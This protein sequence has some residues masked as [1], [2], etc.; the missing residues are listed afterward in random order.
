MNKTIVTIFIIFYFKISLSQEYKYIP[1][2]DSG[3]IWSEV[4]YFPE[5]RWPDTMRKPPSYERFTVNGE[6]T[7]INDI[8]YKKLFMFYDSV[9]IKN[10]ATFI[11]GI[12]E[13][14]NKRVYFKSD[15]FLH[16]FKPMNWMYDY[17]EIILYDFSLDVGDTIKNINC[18][19]EDD[20]LV[21]SKIDSV[22]ID[23]RYRKMFHFNPMPW[24]K[25]IE[26]IGNL[27]GLLFTSGDIPTNGTYGSLIC[28]K[29]NKK[30]LYF[31]NDYSECFPVLTG[32]ETNKEDYS[33]IHVLPNPSN[34][35]IGLC[36]GKHRIRVVQIFDYKGR[37]CGYFNIHLQS[38]LF[39]ST[40]K[41]QPG[42][43][44][45]KATDEKGINITGRFV[46][47]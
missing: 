42:I 17:N 16:E 8:I 44:F 38:D 13:D 45:Y 14:E 11:G 1:F 46:V 20:V 35:N 47:Q 28:F 26:G 32:I 21:I 34:G 40:E 39:L 41:Y 33:N 7:I 10:K 22:L 5:P 29:G 24:I 6:D 31:N 27:N 2:P 18:M 25:W 15:S 23:N 19:P 30:I 43:Y 4:Y 36:F 9:F 12:R 37:Q 3:T